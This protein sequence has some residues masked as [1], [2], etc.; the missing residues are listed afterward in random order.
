MFASAEDPAIEATWTSA[1]AEATRLAETY[2]GKLAPGTLGATELAEALQAVER[3]SQ[4]AMKPVIYANLL[5]AADTSSAEVGAFL[6]AQME[7]SS[8]LSVKL[9]FF[10]LELQK[11]PEDAVAGWLAHPALANYRHYLQLVRVYAPYRLSEAEEV[12]LEE[13]ANTGSRAWQRLFDEVTSNHEFLYTDPHTSER[14]TLSLEQVLDLFRDADRAVRQASAD[15]FTAGLLSMQR[16]LAFTFNTLLQDKN[17]VDRLRTLPSPEASRHLANELDSE[18]VETVVSLCRKHYGLVERFYRVKRQILG[19]PALTHIDRYAP[20]FEAEEKLEWA[21]AKAIVLGA[22]EA[23][24]PTLKAH[25]ERF[26]DG[27]WLDAEVRPGKSGGAFCSGV[28]PDLHPVILMSYQGKMSDVGTLAHEL[29]HGVHAMMSRG[30]SLFNYDTTLPMA[31]LA[32]TFAEM[33]VFEKLVERA[34]RRDKIALYA[35]KIEGTF[36]TVFRQAAMYQ[37]EKRIHAHR[38]SHGELSAEQFGDVWQEELQAMFGDA[39][40]LGDQHRCW[41]MYISH[42]VQVP[43]YVYAYSFGELLSLSLFGM[44]KR[45]GA[46]FEPKYLN[47]LAAGG[48][49]TPHEIAGTVGVDLR[50]ESF[51][52]GG[53]KAI[54]SLVSEF[55]RLWNEEHSN[56]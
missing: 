50:S 26:F 18:T 46:A 54:D 5:F 30:Q 48:S 45:E 38:R 39:V 44:A 21:E 15:A 20:L 36:A 23:F 7:R 24:S 2:R 31:E 27:R 35:E 22:F 34:S 33:L 10:D 52:L 42:F 3:L 29:G 49:K 56:A 6:Q 17:V 53:F 16:V 40:R 13:V 9:L 43:F 37:F 19:L 25:A 12:I 1:D 28:T 14:K 8:A 11:A 55:E 51:W 41:W 4:E 32:S 47:L